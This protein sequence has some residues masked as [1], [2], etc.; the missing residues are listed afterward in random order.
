MHAERTVEVAGSW[1]RAGRA[2][3]EGGAASGFCAPPLCRLRGCPGRGCSAGSGVQ[4]GTRLE[5]PT[6]P[7]Q[8]VSRGGAAGPQDPCGSAL[9]RFSG[10]VQRKL[11]LCGLEASGWGWQLGAQTAEELWWGHARGMGRTGFPRTWA[12]RAGSATGQ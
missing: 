9:W 3:I 6:C 2:R 12:L 8:P 1:V 4:P 7:W 11:R 5:A 10:T